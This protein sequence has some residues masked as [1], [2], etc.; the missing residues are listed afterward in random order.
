MYMHFNIFLNNCQSSI[1]LIT[2]L[3]LADEK[4]SLMTFFIFWAVKYFHIE[5]L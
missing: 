1:N 2:F 3:H 5:I 4:A